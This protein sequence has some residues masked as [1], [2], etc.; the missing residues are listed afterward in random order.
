VTISDRGS[1]IDLVCL[2]MAGT[3]VKD[4]GAVEEAFLAAL[5]AVGVG[6]DDPVRADM[7]TYVRAT[8]GTSKITVFR[9]LFGEE[10]L[11]V[12]ANTA[13]EKAY[14]GIVADGRIA[15]IPGA[16]DAI[17]AIRGEGKKV[18]FLT[19]FSARTRDALLDALGWR[20]LADL[21]LCPSEAGRGRPYPDMI[22]TAILRLGIDDV[23]SV[24]VAG[25]TAA[26]VECALRAGSSVAAGVL[27]G[28]DGR[29]RL[30]EAGA[31]HV[32]ESVTELPAL[33]SGG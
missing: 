3:T 8:M 4:D 17:E 5:A 10:D 29:A 23:A 21:A 14:D 11:A 22:L 26:D 27:T 9:S 13:F 18:A 2:D 25:D 6:E 20:D 24:A 32:L 7:L 31:T 30:L 12:E 16:L 19:G 28:A 15:P 1:R 33:V